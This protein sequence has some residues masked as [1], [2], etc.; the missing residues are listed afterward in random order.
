MYLIKFE[1]KYFGKIKIIEDTAINFGAKLSDGRNLGTI[2]DYGFYSFGLMKVLTTYH[3]GALYIK[4][5]DEFK[6]LTI[7]MINWF[8]IP[9]KIINL[10]FF[11]ILINFFYNKLIFNYFTYYLI[12]Y[13]TKNNI[14][15]LKKLFTLA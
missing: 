2:F 7:I 11:S 8:L 14:S 3:G 9:K 13:F 5:N 12:S 4:D 6:I 10:Y 1:K 15:F